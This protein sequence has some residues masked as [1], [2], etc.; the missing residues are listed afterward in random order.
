ML[1]Y[2]THAQGE[3]EATKAGTLCPFDW[4]QVAVMPI[5]GHA[6]DIV[7]AVGYVFQVL[8]HMHC[9]SVNCMCGSM[10][11]HQCMHRVV[12]TTYSTP[13]RDL[14]TS[15]HRGF[16]GSKL[17]NCKNKKTKKVFSKSKKGDQFFSPPSPPPNRPIGEFSS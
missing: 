15:P 7:H 4:M 17:Q 2:C 9:S 8:K 6:M 13:S 10:K 3:G 16:F 1:A 5:G 14:L 11:Q 12:R